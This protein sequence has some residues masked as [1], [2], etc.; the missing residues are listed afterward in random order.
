M[1][2]RLQLVFAL[3]PISLL[4]GCAAT[5]HGTKTVA[6]ATDQPVAAGADEPAATAKSEKGEEESEAKKAAKKAAKRAKLVSDL[7]IA[8]QKVTQAQLA[9]THQQADD[10]EAVRK[11]AADLDVASA[12]LVEFNERTAPVRLDRARL[13]L[14]GAEDRVVESR[15]ELEQ[16]EMMYAEEELGDKTREIVI[17]R[18][19]RRLARAEWN[20]RIQ[21]TDLANLEGEKIPLE[22]HELELK[23]AAA[24]A[25]HDG[26]MR[27]ANASTLAKQISLMSAEADVVRLDTELKNHDVE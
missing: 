11:A 19:K 12:K 16:L 17:T 26:K 8:R 20:L 27:S 24:S 13:S 18:A 23:V 9:S 21:Q 3:V 14:K 6:S 10:E 5:Q 15:E 7:E 4:V 25:T 2:N 22:R 1:A